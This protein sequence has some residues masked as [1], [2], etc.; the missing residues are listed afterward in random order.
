M[1]KKRVSSKTIT[2]S[3]GKVYFCLLCWKLPVDFDPGIYVV[4]TMASFRLYVVDK[5]ARELYHGTLTFSWLEIISS[6]S[7]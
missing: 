4:N 3:R 2:L 6:K 1:K 5:Y 7:I